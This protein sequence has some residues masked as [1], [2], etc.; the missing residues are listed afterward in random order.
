MR[1]EIPFIS[2]LVGKVGGDYQHIYA[3]STTSVDIPEVA[4]QDAPEAVIWRID[5]TPCD[6]GNGERSTLWHDGGHWTIL[7]HG[8]RG[9]RPEMLAHRSQLLTGVGELIVRGFLN[10]L[11][12]GEPRKVAQAKNLTDLDIARK[13][14]SD[15]QFD[16]SDDVAAAARR[17]A[18]KNIAL[19][20]GHLMIR[21]PEPHIVIGRNFRGGVP[22][23]PTARH[24]VPPGF[25]RAREFDI[26][27]LVSA[28]EA[29]V[30]EAILERIIADGY[31]HHTDEQ[32]EIPF[33]HVA[34]PESINHPW[35]ADSA[36]LA[37]D[38]LVEA[39]RGRLDQMSTDDVR[40]WMLLAKM[41]DTGID[42]EHKALEAMSVADRLQL[43][44]R[45]PPFLV[46]EFRDRLHMSVYGVRPNLELAHGG[47]AP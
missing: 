25:N 35:H 31:H 13:R 36:A 17:L 37:I 20:Y 34:I 33:F 5:G 9:Y 38:M 29:E 45:A 47:I 22:S 21:C 6:S 18:E 27:H 8:T 40:L 12:A 3:R 30:A 28:D 7:S 24:G 19:V 32:T 26:E 2:D 44:L 15:I 39:G 14:L 46:R 42:T 1:I 23:S 41:R 10:L 16:N 43:S 4:A 11:H